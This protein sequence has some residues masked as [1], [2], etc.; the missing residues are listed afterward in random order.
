MRRP[1][2]PRTAAFSIIALAFLTGCGGSPSHPAS[3]SLTGT[4]A[5]AGKDDAIAAMVPAAVRS[6]GV[7]N[8]ATD[9]S[10]PPFEFFDSNNK[11]I[12]GVDAELANR[13]GQVL[14]LKVNVVNVSFDGIIPG[15]Q[16]KR[17]DLGMSSFTDTKKREQVVD[18]VTY[19][20][21]GS[22]VLVPAGN[23]KKLGLFNLCG[24]T[25]AVGKGTIYESTIV[26]E[27]SAE[28]AKAGKPPIVSSVFPNS[29][30]AAL[31]VSNGRAEADVD[32]FA[33]LTYVA[34]QS[35][36]KFEVLPEQYKPS[37]WGIA[38]TKGSGLAE[39]IHAAVQKLMADGTYKQVLKKWD[40]SAGAIDGSSINGAIG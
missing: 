4:A 13:L 21:G 19:F 39:P 18:F 22:A 29:S 2:T 10:Y 24:H 9:A 36:N 1:H 23:P 8:I 27:L 31:A 11:T 35:K 25:V 26:P 38:M 5:A 34:K 6:A 20:H 14:G 15:L 28:C 17:Y 16:S 3:T 12:I 37:P 30:D 40:V 7:L 33:P 32:D